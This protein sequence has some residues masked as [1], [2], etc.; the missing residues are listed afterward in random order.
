MIER[1]TA[2]PA[3][4]HVRRAMTTPT[5]KRAKKT[6]FVEINYRRQTESPLKRKSCKKKTN[7]A[8]LLYLPK[9]Q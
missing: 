5:P 3:Q 9:G 8:D 7:Y 6:K 4:A 2:H 1:M